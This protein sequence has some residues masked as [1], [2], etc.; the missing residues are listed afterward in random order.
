MKGEARL[1]PIAVGLK[2]VSYEREWKVKRQSEPV[3]STVG[4]DEIPA[5]ELVAIGFHGQDLS[6]EPQVDLLREVEAA[7]DEIGLPPLR[8]W[9]HL[10][11]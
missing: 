3:F 4:V 7:D 6:V 1:C 5:V 10:L 11:R 9:I 2:G 8:P